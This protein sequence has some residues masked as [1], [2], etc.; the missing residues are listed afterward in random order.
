MG[1][2]GRPGATLDV[3]RRPATTRS[4][5]GRPRTLRGDHGCQGA[6]LDGRFFDA[7]PANRDGRPDM[8]VITITNQKGGVGKTTTAM[9]L[10]DALDA[11]GHRVLLVDL[12][13]QGNATA[14]ALGGKP[15]KDDGAA[16]LKA[17]GGEGALSRSARRIRYMQKAQVA[18][19]GIVMSQ[20]THAHRNQ[21]GGGHLALRRALDAERDRWDFV[22]VDTPPAEMH[23]INVA[24]AAADFV[25]VPTPL[26]PN[27]V[28]GLA[29]LTH[30]IAEARAGLNPSLQ[31]VGV[32][33][34]NVHES[35][36]LT[37][38]I[39]RDVAE[40]FGE[41]ATLKSYIRAD[42]AVPECDA[43]NRPVRRRKRTRA[44]A[45]YRDAIA[46]IN[47]RITAA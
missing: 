1:D 40:Q 27:A 41:S 11:E 45:D 35:R 19:G 13:P 44:A 31:V 30:T 6:T 38:Q 43:R 34:T 2:L 46:E 25:V 32:L 36:K 22:V 37:A 23:L 42:A 28:R 10:T 17:L 33:P 9:N 26:E 15:S 24:L 8:R 3:Q 16:L 47:A 18:A 14:L 12:D 5:H 21:S 29:D 7:R 20:A 4:V 39:A